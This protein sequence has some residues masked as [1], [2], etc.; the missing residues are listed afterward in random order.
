M[1]YS[2]LEFRSSSHVSFLGLVFEI[3]AIWIQET[4]SIADH[5]PDSHESAAL[6]KPAAS[7]RFAHGGRDLRIIC[8]QAGE[9]FLGMTPPA[10]QTL[11]FEFRRVKSKML[12]Y[13]S[14]I[15]ADLLR[16]CD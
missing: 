16:S 7:L 10:I 8:I 6:G 9:V 15:Q 1:H 5:S 2:T 3:R 11:S 13:S 14:Q 4:I 12:N